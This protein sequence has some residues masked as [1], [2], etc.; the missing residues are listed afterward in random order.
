MR[1]RFL[2][3][4]LILVVVAT[5]V[6]GLTLP[7]R[8]AHADSTSYTTVCDHSATDRCAQLQFNIFS[9]GQP[10][11]LNVAA[12]SDGSTH[13]FVQS[14]GTVSAANG[15]PFKGVASSLNSYYNGRTIYYIEKKQT[16]GTGHD[17]CMG[18]PGNKLPQVGWETCG[19]STVV[20]STSYPNTTLWVFNPFT[21]ASTGYFVNVGWTNHISAGDG[22]ATKLLMSVSFVSGGGCN[23]NTGA[24]LEVHRQ[25]S[26]ECNREW[27]INPNN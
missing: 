2:V 13:W 25:G 27:V 9:A 8:T 26:T 15:T 12:Q 16:D 4:G 18:M 10:I 5:A 14:E 6:F 11:I 3:G 23:D 17:G 7:S 1:K 22:T 24:N 20:G 19:S 21:N